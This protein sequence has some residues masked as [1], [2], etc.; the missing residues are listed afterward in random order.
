[1]FQKVVLVSD[2][3][4]HIGWIYSPLNLANIKI[5]KLKSVRNTTPDNQVLNFMHAN[6]TVAYNSC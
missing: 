6:L 4:D 5:Q 2:F 3:L 1:M